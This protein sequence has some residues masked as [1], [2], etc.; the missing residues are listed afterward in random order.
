MKGKGELHPTGVRR[1]AH[2]YL[3]SRPIVCRGGKGMYKKGAPRARPYF[4]YT[5]TR[6]AAD[7]LIYRRADTA[8]ARGGR[9]LLEQGEVVEL[10][11]VFRMGTAAYLL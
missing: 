4:R 2:P 11:G 1:K 7:G 6:I 10:T 3:L 9:A 8:H 5:L